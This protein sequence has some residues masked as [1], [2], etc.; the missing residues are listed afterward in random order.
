MIDRTQWWPIVLLAA[1]VA[2]GGASVPELGVSPSHQG[3]APAIQSQ[4]TVSVTGVVFDSLTGLP[5]PNADV[6]L[7]GDGASPRVYD[8][9]TD[10]RGHFVVASVESGS[11]LA[12]FFH[13]RLDS[14]GIDFP[15]VRITIAADAPTELQL[16]TP[17]RRSIAASICPRD[18]LQ[19]DG[20]LVFGAVRDAATGDRLTGA[21]VSIQWSMLAVADSALANVHTGELV[22][23]SD[24]GHYAICHVP[25][26]AAVTIRAA[27]GADTSGAVAVQVPPIGIL[28]RDVYVAPRTSAAD[29]A[30]TRLSGRVVTP[31]GEP[32]VGAELSLWGH[33]GE[34]RTNERGTFVFPSVP[35]GSSTLD[36]RRVGFEPARG[37]VDVRT[38]AGQTNTVEIVLARA[39][40]KLAPVTILD[41]R[42]SSVLVRSGFES[43]RK[44]GYGR[45]VDAEGLEKMHVV[46]T[47]EAIGRF[48]G[49]YLKTA[50]RGTR[51]FMRDPQGLAC[52]PM[53]WVDGS[54]Y[55]P[56]AAADVDG[57]VDIDLLA[58]PS[59]IAGIE[60]Y[61]RAVGGAAAVRRYNPVCVRRHRDLA[62]G[63]VASG[64]SSWRERESAGG[65][66]WRGR[67]SAVRRG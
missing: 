20:A 29:S 54:P 25:L 31:D 66:C 55:S 46:N 11:Y 49:M 64:R 62:Q 18:S 42:V 38:G 7:L 57:V 22:P 6:Q 67:R 24:E 44:G 21:V 26:D 43:R 60:I 52:S 2:A 40:T 65:S 47:T 33:D 1:A 36:V 16:A 41:R 28:S 48:P 17:S 34:V 35:G 50:S 15:P 23:V 63:D 37:P 45:F 32:V 27:V 4:K 12:G 51:L 13:P 30:S 8:A 19:E 59:Q 5:L 9:R 61:R 10:N 14:L 53:V 3:A 56:K 39:T 58:N